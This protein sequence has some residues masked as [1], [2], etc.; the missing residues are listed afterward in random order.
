MVD[1]NIVKYCK[2]C[3]KRFVLRKGDVNKNYCDTC[4]QKIDNEINNDMEVNK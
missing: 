4:Q 3:K 2:L 1:Y